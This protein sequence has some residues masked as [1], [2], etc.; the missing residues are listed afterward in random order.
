MFAW[1]EQLA[2]PELCQEERLDLVN[3]LKCA[4]FLNL[5]CQHS[6]PL[7]FSATE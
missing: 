2:L 7:A 5:A 4:L 1:L 3:Q 6:P